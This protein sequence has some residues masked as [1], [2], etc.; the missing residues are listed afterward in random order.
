MPKNGDQ[1]KTLHYAATNI[2]FG[3]AAVHFVYIVLGEE[4]SA[5]RA[6]MK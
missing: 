4:E 6:D 3:M 2:R 5:Q 1:A